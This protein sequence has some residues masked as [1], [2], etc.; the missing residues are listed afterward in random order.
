VNLAPFRAAALLGFRH[1][2]AYRT[3]VVIQLVAASIIA[4][5]NG[6]LWTAA[7]ESATTV[8]GVPTTAVRAGVLVAW[9]GIGAVATRVHED[10]GE[11]FRSGQ[12]AAD[13]VR[14]ISLPGMIY[15]RDLGRAS[16][17]FLVQAVPL[18]LLSA[19]FAPLGLPGE[20]GRWLAWVAALFGAHLVNVALSFSL[21]IGA[22]RIG[23]AT[24]LTHVKA[25]LVSL[26][27]GALLPLEL[28]GPTLQTVAR[29]LPFHLLGRTPAQV[30]VSE[31][32]VLPLLAEQAAWA[33]GLWLFGIWMWKRAARSFTVAGG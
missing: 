32:P 11:R 10:M 33:V 29:C 9:A 8:G 21:G 20:P 28:F 6:A 14:P 25:T 2:L 1:H 24:G 22:F 19:L 5:L 4:V 12:I 30:L 18:L 15:A 17:A 27:A 7:T 3:E 23:S 16:A 13:L 31:A 26:F